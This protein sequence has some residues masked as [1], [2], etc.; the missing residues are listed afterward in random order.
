MNQPPGSSP[1]NQRH[2][3]VASCVVLVL[4]IGACGDD[5]DSAEPPEQTSTTD[6]S[7]TT[8]PTS[9]STTTTST[10]TTTSTTVAPASPEQEVIDR[11]IGFWDARFAA[12]SGTPDPDDPALRDF[13]TGQQLEAVIT[14]TRRNLDEGLA[15]RDRDDPAEVRIVN[16]ISIEGD[17]AVVQE[18]FVDDGLVVRRDTGEVV[19]DTVATHNVRGELTRVDGSWRVSRAQL[20]QRWEGVAGCALG[21]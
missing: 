5:S 13:A 7:P 4:L 18:C 10:S 14:E 8:S 20:V 11:Y 16:V 17:L 15:F 1:R 6:A 9:T 2:R 3:L 19:N 12:N 21:S